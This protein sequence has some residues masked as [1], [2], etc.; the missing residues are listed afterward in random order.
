[1]HN[2][3]YYFIL[4][5]IVVEYL[6]GQLLD[7]LNTTRWSDKLP[8]EVSGIYDEEKY[9][10]S[11]RYEKAKH[12]FSTF[13]GILSFCAILF[14]FAL[15]GFAWFDELVRKWVDHP[16]LTPL[17][18]FATLG[19]IVEILSLPLS[20]YSTFVIEARFGFNRST[21]ALFFTDKL[22]GVIMAALLGGGLLA[23]IIWIYKL[24]GANFWIYALIVIATFSI[25]IT[26]FYSN[27]IVPL[28]NKQKP[29]EDGELK[30][31]IAEFADKVDFKLD[32]I[33]VIDG[34]KR[35]SR[36]NAYFTGF[37]A[38]KRIV[39]YDTLI[40]EMNIPEIVGVLAHEIGHYKKKHVLWGL[41]L[42][43]I[44]TGIM[45]FIFSLVADSEL[46]IQAMGATQPGFH[47]ALIGFGLMYTPL[48][49][50]T[51][52][53][54]NLLSRRNEYQADEFAATNYNSKALA[55]ALKK[56]SVKNLSNL[57]PHPWYVF[58]HYSHPPVL[59]RLRFLKRFI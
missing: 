24:T 28:F 54:M 2:T 37:G 8:P 31:A 46:L 18:Y 48:S 59:E 23:L 51:G 11:Q 45:L 5:I 57:T 30:H 42:S 50:I 19:L 3:L 33:F 17:L 52:L 13:T 20:W 7:Y 36:A 41:I 47:L 35:S 44:N 27:L 39:L 4:S 34:S 53:G 40:E 6:F 16:I 38:K 29:L 12:R 56:L 58:F 26:L 15:G 22:K 25:F 49:F 32:N 43:L 1:M 10:T 14:M 55:E 21:P 9:K